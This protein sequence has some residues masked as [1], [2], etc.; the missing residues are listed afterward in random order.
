MS[1]NTLTLQL[2]LNTAEKK[3]LFYDKFQ[4]KYQTNIKCMPK[5]IIQTKYNQKNMPKVHWPT[6]LELR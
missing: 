6:K 2:F 4:N 3:Y 5:T 1:T